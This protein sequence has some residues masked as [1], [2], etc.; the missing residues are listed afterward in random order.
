VLSY[1]YLKQIQHHLDRE[2]QLNE[3]LEE[4]GKQVDELREIINSS[5]RM[6]KKLFEHVGD[7]KALKEL[8]WKNIITYDSIKDS[9]KRKIKECIKKESTQ[10]K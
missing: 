10:T 7:Q 8:Q 6:I 3:K 9:E 5:Q 4:R 1:D 2:A